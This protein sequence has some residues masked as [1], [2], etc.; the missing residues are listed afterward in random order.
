MKRIIICC[1][2]FLAVVALTPLGSWAVLTAPAGQQ[3]FSF[4]PVAAPSVSA[5]PA[6]AMP[7]GLG[8][9][10][11]GKDTLTVNVA[12]DQFSAPVDI[13]LAF[14]VSTDPDTIVNIKPDLSFQTFSIQTIDQALAAG[15]PPAGIV[16][17]LSNVTTGT[18]VTPFAN[19]PVSTDVPPG[20]YSVFLVAT[21]P[22]SLSSFYLWQT[23]FTIGVPVQTSL[24][25]AQETPAVDSQ[26]IGIADFAVNFDTGE[27]SGTVTFSGLSSNAASAHIH[28]GAVGVNGPVLITLIDGSGAT[29]GV[30]TIPAGTMLSQSEL[31]ALRNNELYFNIHSA[32]NLNGE[33]RGQIIFP[34][35]SIRAALTGAQEVPPRS[36]TGTGIGDLTVNIKTGAISGTVN[37]SGFTNSATAA[38]IHQG[39]AGVIGPIIVNLTG[40]AGATSGVWTI[41]DTLTSAQLTALS[42]NELY[43]NIHTSIYDLGEIRGQIYYPTGAP[44]L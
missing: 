7:V 36:T 17:W 23:D 35:I 25:G 13:Y 20:T 27:I 42:N 43:F 2:I 5:T 31:T 9:V 24:S 28:Q 8:D 14:F 37:F 32:A 22:G 44:N 11:V 19:I 41:S 40:G 34:N 3:S 33:I 26:G 16:P 15:Q 6:N 21:L 18:N 38:H 12:V 1:L 4:I 39:A 10:A 30:W 29:S